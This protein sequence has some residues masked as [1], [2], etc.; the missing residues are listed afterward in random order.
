MGLWKFGF[1]GFELTLL[2]T[3]EAMI[4]CDEKILGLFIQITSS[5]NTALK[6]RTSKSGSNLT[7]LHH[8]FAVNSFFARS[9]EFLGACG[10]VTPEAIDSL[11][12][13]R[14]QDLELHTHHT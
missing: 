11:W 5:E 13:S 9:T 14:Q 8:V 3:C 7:D 6:V 1:E 10:Y 12:S 4:F 2:C